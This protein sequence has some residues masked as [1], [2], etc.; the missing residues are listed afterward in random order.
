M[1]GSLLR[2]FA[3]I[4]LWIGFGLYAHGQV[5][6]LP[7]TASVDGTVSGK[8]DPACEFV[9]QFYTTYIGLWLADEGDTRAV[10]KQNL[11]RTF[12]ERLQCMYEQ[13]E[14]DY[15]PFLNAQDCDESVLEKLRIEK[16][17]LR[18]H[19]YRV[20][21]WDNYH[22]NYKHV[23]LL[24]EHTEQGYRIDDLLSLPDKYRKIR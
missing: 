22:R 8:Q 10:L 3:M 16:D 14:L 19:V 23:E 6:P 11:T 5:V 1:N 21:L 12:Y 15:D 7:D 18:E 20:C 17:T 24:L 2:I 13:E 9:R 4:S